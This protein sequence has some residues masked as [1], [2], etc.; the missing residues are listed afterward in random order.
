MGKFEREAKQETARI[1]EAGV[2]ILIVE[3]WQT[4]GMLDF[5]FFGFFGHFSFSGCSSCS[6]LACC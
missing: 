6:C 3:D 2:A 5:C 4:K 1:L